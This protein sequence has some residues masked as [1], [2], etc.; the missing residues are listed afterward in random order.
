MTIREF[1]VVLFLG[2]FIG[3]CAGYYVGFHQEEKFFRD[4]VARMREWND[5]L[6]GM[7]VPIVE[8]RKKK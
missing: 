7:T 2:F 6:I 8:I 5:K 1:I 3:V 4:E